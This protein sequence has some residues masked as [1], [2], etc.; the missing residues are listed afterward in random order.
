MV[1]FMESFSHILSFLKSLLMRS[2]LGREK[3]EPS[4][5]LVTGTAEYFMFS[6]IL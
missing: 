3:Q 5:V 4:K 2:I 6:W 1:G